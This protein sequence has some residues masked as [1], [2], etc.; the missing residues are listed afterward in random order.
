MHSRSSTSLQTHRRPHHHR[1]RHCCCHRHRRH[2]R[3]RC[4]V[5]QTTNNNRRSRNTNTTHATIKNTHRKR[6]K[7]SSVIRCVRTA[8]PIGSRCTALRAASLDS[9]SLRSSEFDSYQTHRLGATDETSLKMNNSIRDTRTTTN[10]LT[11]ISHN[12]DAECGRAS[13]STACCCVRGTTL[14]PPPLLRDVL[15]VSMSASI[16]SLSR[17][18]SDDDWLVSLRRWRAVC[19]QIL[20]IE[21]IDGR[22]LNRNRESATHRKKKKRATRFRSDSLRLLPTDDNDETETTN[23]DQVE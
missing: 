15:I 9:C 2:R 13:R 11:S 8:M 23:S 22:R 1:R 16:I 21:L 20:E 12:L 4:H 3:R 10:T 6:Q 19:K 14:E 18:A 7:L 17:E 5:R